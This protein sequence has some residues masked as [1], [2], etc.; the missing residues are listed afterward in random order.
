MPDVQDVMGQMGQDGETLGSGCTMAQVSALPLRAIVN[1]QSLMGHDGTRLCP[2]GCRGWRPHIIEWDKITQYIHPS[3]SSFAHSSIHL[4]AQLSPY[5]DTM[6]AR[7]LSHPLIA[8]VG[9]REG[10]GQSDVP[11]CPIVSRLG[12][13]QGHAEVREAEQ[14]SSGVAPVAAG[15]LER[16]QVDDDARVDRGWQGGLGRRRGST[17]WRVTGCQAGRGSRGEGGHVIRSG[18]TAG[19]PA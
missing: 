14:P 7:N 19:G 3:A 13:R 9:C 15:T 12:S 8:L 11:C 16:A 6:C 18:R 10:M 5:T 2:M 1:V 17:R 4:H